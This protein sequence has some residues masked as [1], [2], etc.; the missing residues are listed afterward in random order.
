MGCLGYGKH[1]S[2]KLL[3]WVY[4]DPNAPCLLRKRAIWGDYATRHPDWVRETPSN[5][6]A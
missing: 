6:Y 3:N 1:D 2:I 4:A 5:I